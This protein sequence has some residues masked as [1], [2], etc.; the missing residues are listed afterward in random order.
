M[1]FSSIYF[2]YLATPF[3]AVVAII[4][5][6]SLWIA[7]YSL[8]VCI[9]REKL[10]YLAHRTWHGWRDNT[11]LSRWEGVNSRIRL[12]RT[13]GDRQKLFVL[14]DV[15][16]IRI[17]HQHTSCTWNQTRRIGMFGLSRNLSVWLKR[18][19]LYIFSPGFVRP[20]WEMGTLG[21][22]IYWWKRINDA[23]AGVTGRAWIP[24]LTLLTVAL[25]PIALTTRLYALRCL[26][27]TWPGAVF[28]YPQYLWMW[29]E[30]HGCRQ[31][32][33]LGITHNFRSCERTATT[34][35]Q[36]CLHFIWWR[37]QCVIFAA[38]VAHVSSTILSTCPVCEGMEVAGSWFTCSSGSQASSTECSCVH[39]TTSSTTST[40]VS[41]CNPALHNHQ[42]YLSFFAC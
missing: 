36:W 31:P 10:G 12:R 7:R 25:L 41:S 26:P 18:I 1:K 29:V 2:A 33:T 24:K 15:H 35:S 13:W 16:A 4:C 22:I 14:S 37:P 39:N 8:S 30:K 23:R 5:H 21:G 19:L 32:L 28:M 17:Q 42:L 38:C 6:I 9:W 3:V 34:L 27:W 11:T 40:V 20:F